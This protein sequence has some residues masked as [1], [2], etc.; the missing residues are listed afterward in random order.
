[1]NQTQNEWWKM[2][3]QEKKT[4]EEWANL[5][6]ENMLLQIEIKILKEELSRLKTKLLFYEPIDEPEYIE[7]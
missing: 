3:E 4:I 6:H 1:M 2:S 5:S 7:W